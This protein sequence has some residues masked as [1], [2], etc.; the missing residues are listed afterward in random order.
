M[1]RI[2]RGA[3]AMAVV[4]RAGE[5]LACAAHTKKSALSAA[6]REGLIQEAVP[7]AKKRFVTLCGHHA[8][9]TSANRGIH[10]RTWPRYFGQHSGAALDAV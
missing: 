8:N 1:M 4:G 7:G 5:A 9:V 3:A 6:T 2:H 10:Q